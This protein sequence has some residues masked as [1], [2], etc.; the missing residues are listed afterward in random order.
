MKQRLYR[1]LKVRRAILW[2]R[3]SSKHQQENGA[4]LDTQREFCYQYAKNNN[5]HIV[6]EFG[7]RCESAK[8]DEGKYFVEMKEAAHSIEGVN[9]ILVYSFDRFNRST[10]AIPTAE[11]LWKEG[12]FLISATETTDWDSDAGRK[13]IYESLLAAH[14]DNDKRASKINAGIDGHLQRGNYRFRLPYGYERKRKGKDIFIYVTPEGEKLKQAWNL[15]IQGFS[16]IEIYQYLKAE[17]LF[18]DTNEHTAIKKISAILKNPVY[19]GIVISERLDY[20][21][22]HSHE[23]PILVDEDT[24]NV[25]NG[26]AVHTGYHQDKEPE[27]FP[28]K[29]HL[30]CADCHKA[31][32]GY[33]NKQKKTN[34]HYY[35]KCNTKG[36]G[37][38]IKAS[39]LHQLLKEQLSEYQIN[40]I[41]IPIIKKILHNE[42]TKLDMTQK[43][44]QA[45]LKKRATELSKQIDELHATYALNYGKMPQVVYEAGLC[46]LQGE[47]TNVLSQI[48]EDNVDE[49]NLSNTMSLVD[50]AIVMSSKLG[51]LWDNGSFKN[52]QCL[53]QLVFPEGLYYDREKMDY[54][55]PVVNT[56]F[57]VI[58]GISDDCEMG[59]TKSDSDSASKSLSVVLPGLEP[60]FTA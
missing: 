56:C 22:Y 53:Q 34:R 33:V 47:L 19:C 10:H 17:G 9:I 40:P 29:G 36:C 4:S 46:K 15:K 5:I 48:K 1:D 7:G 35:Y 20:K 3:V 55:T 44:H 32:T 25:A 8:S 24:F 39:V 16:N 27:Y 43:Q 38:N 50:F 37:L 23:I 54:R 2:T 60:G 26:L 42:I 45:V 18:Q 52:K 30:F 14:T 59:K 13:Y 11:S 49:Q 51:S 57:S 31:L 12:I 21:P 41:F 58:K 6:K 28:L